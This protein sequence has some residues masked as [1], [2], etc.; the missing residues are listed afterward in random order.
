MFATG[1]IFIFLFLSFNF[2]S[3]AEKTSGDKLA[4]AGE[5]FINILPSG[6]AA[7]KESRWRSLQQEVEG[8]I[9][10]F[11]SPTSQDPPI[12]SDEKAEDYESH[13]S[14][15][16]FA[17][18]SVD[19][20][21]GKNPDAD[22]YFR[23]IANSLLKKGVSKYGFRC[24]YDLVLKLGV[25]RVSRMNVLVQSSMVLESLSYECLKTINKFYKRFVNQKLNLNQLVEYWACCILINLCR[26]IDSCNSLFLANLKNK[27][28]S[29]EMEYKFALFVI[30]SGR[31]ELEGSYP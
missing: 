29:L 1:I 10:K 14:N 25:A 13:T 15:L 22:S 7:L 31:F 18:L 8:L 19:P 28:A 4:Q 2:L 17:S 6:P 3:A 23:W 24:S 30:Y 11:V 27:I 9:E 26:K 21:L 5:C 16:C 12:V 20:N